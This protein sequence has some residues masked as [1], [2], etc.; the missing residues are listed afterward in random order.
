MLSFLPDKVKSIVEH[1]DFK[2]ERIV[3]LKDEVQ[4]HVTEKDIRAH[5][6]MIKALIMEFPHKVPSAFYCADVLL[7]LNVLM[8]NKLLQVDDP[9]SVA[10]ADGAKLKKMIGALRGLFRHSQGAKSKI[11]ADLKKILKS[12]PKA[13]EA[14]AEEATELTDAEAAGILYTIHRAREIV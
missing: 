11:I 8:G 14:P 3:V 10:L 6:M 2:G 13:A 7:K 9:T 4:M 1:G 5:H 12:K